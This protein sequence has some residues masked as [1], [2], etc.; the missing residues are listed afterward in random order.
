MGGTTRSRSP[1]MRTPGLLLV[2]GLVAVWAPAACRPPW[3]PGYRPAAVL[4][5]AEGNNLNAYETF[6]PFRKQ[7][8]IRARAADPAGLDINGQICFFPD[9]SRRFVAGEDTG[10]PTPPPGWGIFRLRGWKVG[11]FSATQLAKLT[12]TY[13]GARPDVGENYGCGFLSDGR[14]VTSDVGNQAFGP[15][16]GQL[17]VWFPPFNT[18]VGGVGQ[19]RYCKLDVAIGT[20]GQI[21]VDRHDRI[22]VTSSR[23]SRAGV[24]RYS[25]PYPTSDDASGGCGRRDATGAP[26]ADTVQVEQFIRGD[27]EIFGA[28]GI[29]ST[30]RGT[31]FVSSIVP[32]LVVE[33]DAQ[34][35]FLRRVVEPRS[36]E[37]FPNYA[38]GTPFGLAV[39]R[40]G[41]L[42]YADLNLVV[43][44]GIGPGPDG[45][46]WR[47]P[48]VRGAPA[49][50][51][52]MDAGLR[53][54]DGLG[55][56]EHPGLRR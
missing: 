33:Y 56:L 49:T 15:E 54:P 43:G 7:T 16:N 53:F 13:Q 40:R 4:F 24:L 51:E 10:Q 46:V 18:G 21:H 47:V 29:A 45:K 12:P 2:A 34:G 19:V 22:Y 27:V 5:S 11:E 28:N 6:P 26:L 20:A 41:T 23:G 39:D 44:A 42:Y 48:F 25:P 37:G 9:G 14:I 35:R 1:W 38:Y 17:I 50:P 8:V 31:F 32:G 36:G 3:K 30:P 55:L 52:R